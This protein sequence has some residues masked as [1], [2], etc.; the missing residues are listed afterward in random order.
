M[1]GNTQNLLCTVVHVQYM[2]TYV[3]EHHIHFGMCVHM[4]RLVHVLCVV[5]T[6]SVIV[7]GKTK[8]R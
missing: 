1:V 6:V 7:T 3:I 5:L 2:Y 4:D 8:H